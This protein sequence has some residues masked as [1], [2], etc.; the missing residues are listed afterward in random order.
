[1]QNAHG[2]VQVHA[3]RIKDT[4]GECKWHVTSITE[5][6]VVDAQT[7]SFFLGESL[8][9]ER[10]GWRQCGASD[11]SDDSA[12]NSAAAVAIVL[13]GIVED[14]AFNGV[15]KIPHGPGYERF[16][17]ALAVLQMRRL[18]N[19]SIKCLFATLIPPKDL[20]NDLCW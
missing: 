15:N 20:F 17:D 9:D 1:M 14:R 16:H 19:D 4:D 8:D 5:G 18:Q 7:K 6:Q 2:W 12:S 10:P 3:K 11:T 13:S